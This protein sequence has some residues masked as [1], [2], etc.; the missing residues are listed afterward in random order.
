MARMVER[1]RDYGIE[2]MQI[3]AEL[4]SE[5]PRSNPRT[6]APNYEGSRN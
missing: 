3:S 2:I 1:Y 5:M 4:E 6:S